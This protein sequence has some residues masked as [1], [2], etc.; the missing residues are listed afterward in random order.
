MVGYGAWVLIIARPVVGR[1]FTAPFIGADV[2]GAGVLIV[3]FH[4]IPQAGALH[5]VVRYGARVA[6]FTGPTLQHFIG[7]TLIPQTFVFGAGIVIFA[8]MDVCTL[9]EVRFVNL[10]VA[11]VV[12][13][14]AGLNGRG[15]SVAFEQS[16]FSANSL[17]F[18]ESEF[19]LHLAWRPKGESHR[20]P[21]AR[22]LPRVCHALRRVDAINCDRRQT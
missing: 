17:A 7:A 13:A 5:A 14:V 15:K 2:V 22:A 4:R 12:E 18:A 16:L 21:G 11:V 10:S 20:I 6:I 8:E 1:V 3:T 9:H 19:V